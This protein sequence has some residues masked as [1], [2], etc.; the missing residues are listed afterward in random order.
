MCWFSSFMKYNTNLTSG[1]HSPNFKVNPIRI[2]LAHINQTAAI[3]NIVVIIRRP[4]KKSLDSDVEN[5]F[6]VVY[7][8]TEQSIG[9]IACVMFARRYLHVNDFSL[10]LPPH[11]P[12]FF[13]AHKKVPSIYLCI[14]FSKLITPKP[15]TR[16][17]DTKNNNKMKT[18]CS[19][20]NE[21]YFIR[22]L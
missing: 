15:R 5:K 14:Q 13:M 7:Q 16:Y 20:S 21:L 18:T 9:Y 1:D 6:G 17:S 3:I 4:T 19:N 8:S 12:K 2:T 10:S 22:K 11:F